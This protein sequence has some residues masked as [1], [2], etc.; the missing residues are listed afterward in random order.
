M[1]NKDK[2]ELKETNVNFKST[3]SFKNEYIAFC[4]KKGFSLSRRLRVLMQMDINGEID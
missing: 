3:E 1:V 2:K 4:K